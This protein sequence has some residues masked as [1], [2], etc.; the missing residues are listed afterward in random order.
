[1]SG[2]PAYSRGYVKVALNFP[3]FEQEP[4]ILDLPAPASRLWPRPGKGAT[5]H[6]ASPT[7]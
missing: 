1:M 5:E 6:P 4:V 3:P 2:V 7:N